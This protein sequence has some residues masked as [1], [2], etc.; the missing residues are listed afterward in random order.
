MHSW[1]IK[2][3]ERSLINHPQAI[4]NKDLQNFISNCKSCHAI[5]HD[6]ALSAIVYEVLYNNDETYILKIPF[7][8]ARWKREL[9]CLKLLQDLLPV[10]KIVREFTPIGAFPGAILMTKFNGLPIKEEE[11]TTELVFAIGEYL[12]KL[13]TIKIDCYQDFANSDKTINT[14]TSILEEYFQESLTECKLIVSH[15]LLAKSEQVFQK[16]LP[17]ASDLDGPSIIHRDYRPGNILMNNKQTIIGIID[18]ENAMGGFTQDD[19]SRMEIMMWTK[20]PKLR[21]PFLEGYN[22]IRKLP[23][24]DFLPLLKVC[25]LLGA[26]GFTVVR[27]TWNNKHADSYKNNI[28]MLTSLLT[29][30]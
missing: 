14:P 10:A 9:F 15:E 26:I 2:T 12:A 27:K 28:V 7:S 6:D 17:N 19:F 29:N 16:L 3:G 20:Y 25:K 18:F 13:H 11:L 22:S 4:D 5:V 30:F 23:N 24:L 1:S 8:N 21:I